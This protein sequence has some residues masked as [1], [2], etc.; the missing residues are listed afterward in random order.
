M[1]G[2]IV[3]LFDWRFAAVAQAIPSLRAL[4][5]SH[6][7]VSPPHA[8]NAAVWQWWGRYQPVS[9]DRID[10]P[11]GDA[12]AFAQMARVGALHGVAIIADVVAANPCGPPGMLF[13]HAV[14]ADQAGAYAAGLQYLQTMLDLGAG[15]FRFDGAHRVP[16]SFLR[17]VRE[18]MPRAALIGEIVTDDLAELSAHAAVPGLRLYDFPLLAAMRDAFAPDGDLRSLLDPEQRGRALADAGAIGFVR[19]HDIERGQSDDC[20]IDDPAYRARFGVGWDEAEQRLDRSA[21]RLAHAFI[22][23]RAAGL[24]YVLSGLPAE[25]G[26]DRHD[27]PFLVA[28]LRFRALCGGGRSEVPLLATKDALVWRRGNDRIVAINR[29]ATPLALDGLETGLAAGRYRDLPTGWPLDIDGA[30]MLRSWTLPP[31]WAGLF[32][33]ELA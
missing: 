10:G 4:G 21:V 20:G 16:P 30:A 5:Y 15:G 13:G 6:V 22:F 33:R 24:P 11:L 29:A 17:L 26:A 28:C 8:S 23:G 1:N 31:H 19:N 9:Y 7:H 3:Q 12:A 18:A 32:T 27:D 14:A 25:A 2:A